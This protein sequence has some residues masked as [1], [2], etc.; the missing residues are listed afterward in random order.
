MAAK[1]D[2]PYCL[3]YPNIYKPHIPENKQNHL[4]VQGSPPGPWIHECMC[5]ALLQHIESTKKN[6]QKHHDGCLVI[7]WG[8]QYDHLVPEVIR[9]CN[10]QVPL[11]DLNAGEVFPMV[12]VGDFTL[13]D[14]IFPGSPGDSLLYTNAELDKLQSKGYQVANISHQQRHLNLLSTLERGTALPMK[15]GSWLRW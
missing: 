2:P 15:V 1:T 4:N 13:K 5:H 11:M 12:S 10:H 14:N 3:V 9:P 7:P 6:Q 8:A